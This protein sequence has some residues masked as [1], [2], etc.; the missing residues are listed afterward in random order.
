[1]VKIR[2]A[3]INVVLIDF[4]I[5]DFT[6]FLTSNIIVNI[7][8]DQLKMI[9]LSSRGSYPKLNINPVS[10]SVSFCHSSKYFFY[11]FYNCINQLFYVYGFS[12]RVAHWDMALLNGLKP[13]P[14]T[15]ENYRVRCSLVS[16]IQFWFIGVVLVFCLL[17][18]SISLCFISVHMIW[19]FK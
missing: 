19:L 6:N 11:Y 17:K 14:F 7:L 1:M 5:D 4:C 3:S 2:V 15:R 13:N 12:L 10:W 18:W 9:L 16:E 8:I